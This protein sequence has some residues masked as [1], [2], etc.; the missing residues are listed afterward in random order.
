MVRMRQ[1]LKDQET[2]CCGRAVK[3]C[4]F[5]C[6]CSGARQPDADQM[7][8]TRV[9]Q[10]KGSTL[11]TCALPMLGRLP[12]QRRRSFDRNLALKHGPDTTMQECASRW[13]E[14]LQ[15]CVRKQI[16]PARKAIRSPSRLI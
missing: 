12:H 6:F 1:L 16:V 4:F 7:G 11:V 3:Q 8:R 10:R 2:V 15:C 5:I 14:T 13:S 9:C